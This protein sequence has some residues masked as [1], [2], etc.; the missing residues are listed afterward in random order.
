MDE[1]RVFKFGVRDDHSK[2]QPTDGRLPMKGVWSRHVTHFKF[3]F[4]PKIYLEQLKLD[5]SYFNCVHW[6]AM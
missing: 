1:R 3:L 6:L 2:S 5:I 4:P